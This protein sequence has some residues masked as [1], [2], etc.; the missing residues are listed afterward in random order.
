MR[1]WIPHISFTLD[2]TLWKTNKK[3]RCTLGSFAVQVR[4]ILQ[5]IGDIFSTIFLP[6]LYLSLPCHTRHST[7]RQP[8]RNLQ[9]WETLDCS[10]GGEKFHKAFFVVK[11]V[12][13][14]IL[15]LFF[16]FLLW[17]GTH[18]YFCFSLLF[19]SCVCVCLFFLSFFWSGYKVETFEPFNQQN[20]QSITL[21]MPHLC[22]RA[23]L[24][25]RIL[26][27]KI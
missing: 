16:I 21:S 14:L 19:L 2:L 27:R 11:L 15:K 26:E 22:L 25:V 3:T 8:H 6:S 10:I 17:C 4:I 23:H 5:G 20:E 18:N 12:W 1:D 7:L 9:E 24:A 13:N